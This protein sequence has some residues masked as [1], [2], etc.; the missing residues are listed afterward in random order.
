[1]IE[2]TGNIWDYHA[3]GNWI[4]VTT[5][6]ITRT[7]GA[8]VMGRGIALQAKQKYPR[9]AFELG[10]KLREQGNHVH[11]FPEYKII[12]FPVKYHWKEPAD[13]SLIEQSARELF[14]VSLGMEPETMFY[15]VRPGCGNGQLKWGQ[16]KP[17]LRILGDQ[18]IVVEWM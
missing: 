12:S 16:V 6:G 10:E 13:C 18:F 3:S 2:I 1:M 4:V 11:V 7:D 9:L 5:N 17:L 14:D 8:C 15:M